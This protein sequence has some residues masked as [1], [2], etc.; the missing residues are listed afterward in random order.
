MSLIELFQFSTF[1]TIWIGL[2]GQLG[3]C[4]LFGSRQWMKYRI[5]RAY[6]FKSTAML[7]I[8][9]RSALLLTVFGMRPDVSAPAWVHISAIALN[10]YVLWAIWYQFIALIIDVRS[11]RD[12]LD[13]EL[14]T[15]SS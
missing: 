7:A 15:E 1:W 5:T 9:V 14:R 12:A 4:L 3:F 6:F 11:G 2:V 13:A 8:F 10:T